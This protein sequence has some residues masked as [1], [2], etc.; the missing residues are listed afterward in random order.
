MLLVLEY[1]FW[2][3]FVLYL[4]CFVCFCFCLDMIGG[5]LKKGERKGEGKGNTKV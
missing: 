4:V 1:G 3:L 5:G 2:G